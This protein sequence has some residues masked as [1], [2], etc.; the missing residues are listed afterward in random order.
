MKENFC[1]FEDAFMFVKNKR[2]QIFPNFGF[3]QQL[4]KLEIEM[5]LITN[6]QYKEELK[7]KTVL[8][9]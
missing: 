1:K 5:G 2:S 7:L 6:E 8:V 3:Q 9:K 4:K